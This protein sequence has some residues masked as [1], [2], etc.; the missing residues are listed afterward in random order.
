M[1]SSSKNKNGRFLFKADQRP[2]FFKF[3]LNDSA[4]QQKLV[5][6]RK[7][8]K[9]FGGY[10]SNPV[11][12][13]VPSGQKWK[14]DIVKCEGEICLQSGW[15]EF[16]EYY[17]IEYGYLLVFEYD[18]AVSEFNVIIFDKTT[19][20]IDYPFSFTNVD[21]DP[22]I[23]ADEP[24]IDDV[25]V[26]ILPSKANLGDQFT[27]KKKLTRE[28]KSKAVERAVSNFQSENP[29]FTIVMQPSYVHNTNVMPP[30][31]LGFA[32]KY[33]N[34][35]GDAAIL[36]MLDGKSWSIKYCSSTNSGTTITRIKNSG[37]RG[38]VKGNDLEVGDV[39]I[40]EILFEY[41]DET[42]FGVSIFRYSNL[43]S[44]PGSGKQ[45]KEKESCSKQSKFSSGICNVKNEN[46]TRKKIKLE[47][48]EGSKN[49]TKARSNLSSENPA[50]KTVMQASN[51]SSKNK[52][53]LRLPYNFVKNMKQGSYKVKLQVDNK[54]WSVK[55]N[56]YAYAGIF[57]EGWVEFA[58]ENSLKVGD[59]C[60]FELI[61]TQILLMGVSVSRS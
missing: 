48:S 14:V 1:A 44:S 19:T 32:R 11:I 47:N 25:S 50:C 6:P 39:C 60:R 31:P 21:Q 3:I 23:V 2:H 36:N 59:V 41:V 26:E 52:Y 8:V 33:L 13:K 45:S 56:I 17:S 53:Y 15:R 49:N 29:S 61:D 55:L 35:N 28:E 38:F 30:I 58:R 16:A 43:C 18:K 12:L 7:F 57:G 5:I 34:K 24:E 10:L 40:F 54:L 27:R 51:F 42:T 46:H 20:E 22:N 9:T 4:P 37:W